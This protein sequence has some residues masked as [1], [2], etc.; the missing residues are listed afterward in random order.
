[1]SGRTARWALW[2]TVGENPDGTAEL[3]ANLIAL[4]IAV[5]DFSLSLYGFLAKK[6]GGKILGLALS[7][8]A[9]FLAL[10]GLLIVTNPSHSLA[11]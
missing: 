6:T 5:T 8:G 11:I 2:F 4:G 1:L 10:F 3:A 9:L 7:G